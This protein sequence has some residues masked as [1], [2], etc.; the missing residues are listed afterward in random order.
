MPYSHAARRA[1]S[2]C[3]VTLAVSA[4][5]ALAATSVQDGNYQGTTSY[6][7]KHGQGFAGIS[8]EDRRLT[9]FDMASKRTCRDR[10]GHV[11]R[12]NSGPGS[13]A[14]HFQTKPRIGADGR[15]KA[16]G[17]Y[18]RFGKKSRHGR[19]HMVFTG[20]FKDDSAKGVWSQ[21][22]KLGPSWNRLRCTVKRV[23]WHVTLRQE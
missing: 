12:S 9:Y 8:V 5:S 6:H 21:R 23:T 11:D 7:S 22:Y 15:F 1:A 16:S 10:H 17:R 4:G 18:T 13:F 19:L 3:L 20:R 14:G 2:V